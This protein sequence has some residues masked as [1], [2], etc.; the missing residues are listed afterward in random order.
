[1]NTLTIKYSYDGVPTCEDFANDD[2]FIRGLMGPVG[3]GKSSACVAEIVARGMAQAPGPD[4]IRRSRWA[5]IRIYL[6]GIERH[7]HP[8]HPTM[9]AGYLFRQ[10]HRASQAKV[11]DYRITQTEIELVFLALDRPDDIK[12]LLSLELTGAWVNEAREI[13]W[14]VIDALQARVGRFPAI[15]DGGCT[16]F[17]IF[18]DTNPPDSD[19]KWYKFFEESNTQVRVLCDIQTAERTARQ[20]RKP[21]QSATRLLHQ[22]DG[23]KISGMDQGLSPRRIWLCHGGQ[24]GL[25]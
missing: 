8:H 23:G 25:S 13:E 14:P 24:A 16:W 19:S 21:T 2:S 5:V 17:G 4:G 6:R 3:G 20:R 10:I 18:M 12:K 9:A 7:Y 11:P 1:M 15:R 22:P